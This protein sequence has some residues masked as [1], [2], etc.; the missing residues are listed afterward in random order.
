MQYGRR[1]AT[2][3]S[4][5][6]ERVEGGS[7]PSL[8]ALDTLHRLCPNKGTSCIFTYTKVIQSCLYYL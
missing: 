2:A 1:M 6:G 5:T 3:A 4:P 8:I 7:C